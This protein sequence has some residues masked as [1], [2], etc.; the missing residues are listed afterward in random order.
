[1]LAIEYHRHDDA[2][3]GDGGNRGDSAASSNFVAPLLQDADQRVLALTHP[4]VAAVNSLEEEDL[5]DAV[6]AALRLSP[7]GGATHSRSTSP[8]P[9]DRTPAAGGTLVVRNAA[10]GLASRMAN[11]SLRELLDYVLSDSDLSNVLSLLAT[12]GG[13][14]GCPPAS[15][16]AIE[17][18]PEVTLTDADAQAASCAICLADL[19]CGPVKAMPCG[20]PR[21]PHAFHAPCINAW[22]R[23]HNSCPTCRASLAEQ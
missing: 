11:G 6:A 8:S 22:L 15:T 10:G 23:L 19:G 13:N 1:M 12:V 18:V 5:A 4:S 20:T 17:A 21:V 9:R 7:E 16:A 14:T 3:A 2:Q